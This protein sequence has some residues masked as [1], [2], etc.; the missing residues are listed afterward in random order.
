MQDIGARIRERRTHLGWTVMKLAT[1]AE[2]DSGF[3]SR[4]ETGKASGSMATY[5]K[6]AGAMG[7]SLESLLVTTTNVEAAEIGGRKIPILD[8]SQAG[9]AG[10]GKP[11]PGNEQAQEFTLTDLEHPSAAFALR[12]QGDSM[13]PEYKAGDIVVINPNIEPV[14]G[15]F[16]IA[17]ETGET[18]FRQYRAA[19]RNEAGAD[20]FE[21]TPLNPLYAP[22]RSD[23]V[24]L[25]IV[26][27][28]VEHRRFRRRG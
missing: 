25:A 6:L 13:E 4:I 3:L 7:A 18:M 9:Q 19:G 11:Y 16:V 1:L 5:I 17:T 24:E 21:L 8:Y 15:D 22:M 12:I 23:R 28:M 2:I 10:R 26:G 14:P 20:V 27:V